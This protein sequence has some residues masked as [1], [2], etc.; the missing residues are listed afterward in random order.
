MRHAIKAT[1]EQKATKHLKQKLGT[2]MQKKISFVF[3][4]L[5]FLNLVFLEKLEILEVGRVWKSHLA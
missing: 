5:S 3:I 4:Q 2:K 1:Y